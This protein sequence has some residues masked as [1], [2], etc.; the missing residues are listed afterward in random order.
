MR[1]LI[2]TGMLEDVGAVGY[3]AASVASVLERA[4]LG[5]ASAGDFP[6]KQACY[7]E[8]FDD[9]IGQIEAIM[10]TAAAGETDWRAKLR[11]GLGAL[12]DHLDGDATVARALFVEVHAAGPDALERRTVAIRRAADFIDRAKLEPGAEGGPHLAPEGIVA[13]IHA[14]VHARLSA[15]AERGFRPLL[16]EFMYFAVLPYFGPEAAHAEMLAAQA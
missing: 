16:P 9:A 4:G 7:L 15:G 10:A 2:L 5:D 13:G 8:A 6:D 1:Q 14:V 11:A 12:L 3:D